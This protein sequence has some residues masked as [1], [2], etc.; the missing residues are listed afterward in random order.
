LHYLI[1]AGRNDDAERGMSNELTFLHSAA[2]PRYSYQIDKH[3]NGYHALQFMQ[4]GSIRLAYGNHEQILQGAWMWATYP[5]PRIAF[6]PDRPGGWWNHRY[7]AFSGPRV[8]R[9][10]GEGLWGGEALAVYEPEDM[11]RRFDRLLELSRRED[12]LGQERAVNLLEGIL[13]ELAEQRQQPERREA[14]LQQ[15]LDLLEPGAARSPVIEALAQRVGLP[16]STLRRRFKQALGLSINA[17]AVSRRIS[18]ACE[19]LAES[20]VSIGEIAEALGYTDIY[21]FSRQFRQ[22]TGLSP[23]A[24]RKSRL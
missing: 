6:G 20:A 22:R 5:G 13:L 16:A 10:Q 19:L 12:R 1:R 11:A 8:A 2:Y 23:S 24:Y 3:F 21:F 18:R 17:Y 4:A 15:T 9:W 14:W 7:L